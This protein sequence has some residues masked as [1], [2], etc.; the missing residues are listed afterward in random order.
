MNLYT[1]LKKIGDL[2]KRSPQAWRIER[3]INA[4]PV[5]WARR[6]GGLERQSEYLCPQ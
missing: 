6:S 3:R 1:Y 2:V 4:H 5:G